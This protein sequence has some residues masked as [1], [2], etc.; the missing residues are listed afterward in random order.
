MVPNL[1]R[2]AIYYKQGCCLFCGLKEPIA[3]LD[4]HHINP[5][6]KKKNISE[7]SSWSNDLIEELNK[8]ALLCK[9]CHCKIHSGVISHDIFEIL[10][11]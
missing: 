11:E 9:N 1:K 2:Q 7:F 5:Q 4:F 3:S 6:Y 10:E 8:C